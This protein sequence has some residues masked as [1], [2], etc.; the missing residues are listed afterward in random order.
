MSEPQ[1]S[2][3]PDRK[4]GDEWADWDGTVQEYVS[5]DTDPR[6]FIGLSFATILV[7]L[8]ATAL[9]GWLIYPRLIQLGSVY[10]Q[11]FTV[12]YYTLAA[13]LML[14]LVL[15]IGVF[16]SGR[17]FLSGFIIVPK[18]VNI[19]LDLSMKIGRVF[20][21]SRDRLANSFLKLHNLILNTDPRRVPPEKLLLLLP[22]CLSRDMNKAMRG[23][24]DKYG[25]IVATAEGGGE[26]RN[27]I[28]EVRPKIIIAVAC[29]RDL[30]TGFIDVNP[31]IPVIG[32][33]NIRPCGP[34]KDTEVDLV[35]IEATV[36][37]HLAATG[38][39]VA[40]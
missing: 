24:R 35:S 2:K 20:G 21:V 31:H 12:L 16:L 25:I 27:K 8:G 11:V 29:E 39:S 34:C 40:A 13:I 18:L 1:K 14:W 5:T 22:R 33:P 10:S 17:P 32:F 38:D 26:A 6:V 15:F 36:K 3:K 30:L 7:I 4:L 9:F 19:L 37:R 28:R 23:I